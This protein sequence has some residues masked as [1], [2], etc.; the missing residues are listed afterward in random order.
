MNWGIGP[1]AGP[2]RKQYQNSPVGLWY[3][4]FPYDADVYLLSQLRLPSSYD[5]ATAPALTATY[6]FDDNTTTED[7]A[8]VLY[9]GDGATGIMPDRPADLALGNGVTA[10]LSPTAT[11]GQFQ[12][13]TFSMTT[14]TFAA[15]AELLLAFKVDT[16]NPSFDATHALCLGDCNLAISVA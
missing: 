7:F 1:A 4:E 16:A 9:H 3:W 12:S 2:V 15:G 6:W 13:E 11:A 8:L 5:G 10:L 14:N